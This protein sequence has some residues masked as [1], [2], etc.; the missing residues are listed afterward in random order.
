MRSLDCGRN[1]FSGACKE[2]G[3]GM[4]EW[5]RDSVQR[6]PDSS[7]SVV[8]DGGVKSVCGLK[9]GLVQPHARVDRVWRH[10]CTMEG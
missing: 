4:G 3:G 7:E 2:G 6:A 8:K 5:S 10:S 9:A 1:R